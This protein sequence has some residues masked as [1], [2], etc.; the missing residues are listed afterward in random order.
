MTGRQQT[1]MHHPCYLA[2]ETM[3]PRFCWRKNAMSYVLTI[4]AG[5]E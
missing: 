3:H 5:Y 2:C 4:N 1:A